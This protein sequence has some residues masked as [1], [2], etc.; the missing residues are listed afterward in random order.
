MQML[1]EAIY[2]LSISLQLTAA[3]LLISNTSLKL[4]ALVKTA[5]KKQGAIIMVDKKG[6]LKDLEFVRQTAEEAIKNKVAFIML[7]V[8]YLSGVIG[9]QVESN[10]CIEFVVILVF[11]VGLFYL[12]GYVAKRYSQSSK[13]IRININDMI[14][15]S[16]T[17]LMEIQDETKE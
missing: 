16:G 8:G 4:E 10:K 17:T 9:Q 2:I 6:N 1:F 14:I 5:M 12:F 3:L 7:F 13:Y 15:P 11:S